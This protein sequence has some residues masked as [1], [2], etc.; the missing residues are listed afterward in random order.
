MVVGETYRLNTNW[1]KLPKGLK[2]KLMAILEYK[3]LSY[4]GGKMYSAVIEIH[5]GGSCWR[6]HSSTDSI[7]IEQD[8]SLTDDTSITYV[9]L[10]YLEPLN[11]LDDKIIIWNLAT[12]WNSKLADSYG[13]WRQESIEKYGYDIHKLIYEKK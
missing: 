11:P 12:K 4:G 1:T 2:V 5:K 9:P 13:K 10:N 6:H 3:T 8:E 7:V